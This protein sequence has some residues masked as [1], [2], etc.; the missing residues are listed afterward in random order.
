MR[1]GR[2]PKPWSLKAK[3]GYPSTDAP[4]EG[5]PEPP[6]PP[7]IQPPEWVVG[8]VLE[9][10]NAVVPTLTQMRVMTT[11]DVNPIA[12]Y[13]DSVVLWLK[14]RDFIHEHGS[15]FVQ[16]AKV[17]VQRVLDDGQ[18]VE[19]FP[20]IG[21]SQYPQVWEY[22]QL[23]RLLLA[24]EAEYGMTPSSR[25][26]INVHAQ[27]P[28]DPQSARRLEFFRSGGKPAGASKAM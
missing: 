4:P 22:R 3:K 8:P 6:A 11:A 12:R 23:S 17:A 25:T 27:G 19:E 16:R 1:A 20:V 21:I 7:S 24:I 18:I 10:W 9:V 14:A 5:M 2:K 15:T 28:L 26:R 13:C